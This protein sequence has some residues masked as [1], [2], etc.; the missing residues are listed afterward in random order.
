MQVDPLR[1]WCADCDKVLQGM[2]LLEGRMG[3]ETGGCHFCPKSGMSLC[4]PHMG[5]TLTVFRII[6]LC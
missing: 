2:L 4:F 1:V 3:S 5:P 6:P